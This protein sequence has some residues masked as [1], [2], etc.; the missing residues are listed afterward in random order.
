MHSDSRVQ[1]ARC[2][3][4]RRRRSPS[5]RQE[6]P[7]FSLCGRNSYVVPYIA[8]E[9]D[10]RKTEF[11]DL[12]RGT[13]F[14]RL[15]GAGIA[16]CVRMRASPLAVLLACLLHVLPC[17]GWCCRSCW[18]CLCNA[19]G[20]CPVPT[21]VELPS[22]PVQHWPPAEVERFLQSLAPSGSRQTCPASCPIPHIFNTRRAVRLP[23]ARSAR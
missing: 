18:K 14:R 17:S 1:R 9:R 11:G 7:S 20:R 10:F 16:R 12:E 15:V 6:H 21:F 5:S 3:S 8:Y 22:T 23:L 2:L 4:S 13:F 19:Y